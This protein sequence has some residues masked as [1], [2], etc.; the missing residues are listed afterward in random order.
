MSNLLSTAKNL[1]K[2]QA[3]VLYDIYAEDIPLKKEDYRSH[4]ANLGE[5]LFE[6]DSINLFSELIAKLESNSFSELGY[7][8]D[9]EDLLEE[10]LEK[11]KKSQ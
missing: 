7:D 5:R 11:V 4:Y 8:S 10:F 1:L 2:D 9:D 3:I 6:I